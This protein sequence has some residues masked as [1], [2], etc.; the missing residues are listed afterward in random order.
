MKHVL[1][2]SVVVAAIALLAAVSVRTVLAE[3]AD[4]V[5]PPLVGRLDWLSGVLSVLLITAAGARV[6]AEVVAR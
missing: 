3:R 2:W 5:D 4:G 1:V 6:A